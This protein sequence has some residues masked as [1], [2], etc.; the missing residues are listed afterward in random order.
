M[1]KQIVD[2]Y[3][4]VPSLL[5]STSADTFFQLPDELW[6]KIGLLKAVQVSFAKFLDQLGIYI[7]PSNIRRPLPFQGRIHDKFLTAINLVNYNQN[8]DQVNILVGLGSFAASTKEL[9]SVRRGKY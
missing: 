2:A 1:R 8:V 7:K 5:N 9:F 4:Q 6:E 3:N